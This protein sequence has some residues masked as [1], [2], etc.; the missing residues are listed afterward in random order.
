[1]PVPTIAFCGIDGS[2]KTTMINGLLR[3]SF[4]SRCLAVRQNYRRNVEDL[5]DLFPDAPTDPTNYLRGPFAIQARWAYAFDFLTFFRLEVSK[6]C[7]ERKPLLADRWFPC[8]LAWAC[9]V[10]DADIEPIATICETAPLPSVIIH[11][12]V[13]PEI[14]RQR[15]EARGTPTPDEDLSLL[16]A[17]HQG[18][19]QS[20][21]RFPVPIHTVDG[22]S[23]F[24]LD[25]VGRIVRMFI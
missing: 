7:A 15:I 8:V 16:R 6:L 5:L 3:Q 2:G 24:V 13:A 20:F 12:S 11:V 9:A 25:E 1:M 10:E 14:A 4:F 17:Y 22:T 23:P 19:A 21:P 18:Y